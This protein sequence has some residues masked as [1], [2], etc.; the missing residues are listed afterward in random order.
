MT[1]ILLLSSPSYTK[2]ISNYFLPLSTLLPIPTN[3]LLSSLSLVPIRNKFTSIWQLRDWLRNCMAMQ[4][5]TAHPLLMSWST[6]THLNGKHC[7]DSWMRV[8]L[9]YLV[10]N[11]G[12][13]LKTLSGPWN[14]RTMSMM[15]SS[16]IILWSARTCRSNHWALWWL[17]M[18]GQER[19]VRCIILQNGTQKSQASSSLVKPEERL[20][21]VMIG[22]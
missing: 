6:L 11:Y 18:T 17:I 1:L 12:K 20:R 2:R 3:L 5:W 8:L 7:I 19:Q 13:L 16:L 4:R 9:S 21:M 14:L 15:I 22:N 10:L